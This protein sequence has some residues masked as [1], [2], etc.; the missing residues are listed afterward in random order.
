MSQL[1]A[2]LN[3]PGSA[4]ALAHAVGVSEATVSQWRSHQKTPSPAMAVAIER[5]S[6]FAVRRW[7][8]RPEDWH[9]IWPELIGKKGAPAVPESTERVA[10]G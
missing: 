8:L 5:A 6:G 4:R 10:N 7:D 1:D 2:Y 9:R 3:E